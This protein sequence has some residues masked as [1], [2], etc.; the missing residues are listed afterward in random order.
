MKGAQSLWDEE[1]AASMPIAQRLDL[2]DTIPDDHWGEIYIIARMPKA[3]AIDAGIDV[4]HAMA[5]LIRDMLPLYKAAVS[6]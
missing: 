4:A 5:S 2:L 6:A 3:D 1:Q